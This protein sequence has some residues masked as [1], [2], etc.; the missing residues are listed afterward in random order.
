M[1]AG[2]K[3]MVAAA[4]LT[5][6]A[7]GLGC[8]E[9]RPENAGYNTPLQNKYQPV[10]PEAR[11]PLGKEWMKHPTDEGDTPDRQP[12]NDRSNTEEDQGR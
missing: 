1:K 8:T 6:G 4:V 3:S 5:G 9:Q 11:E 7:L 10:K 12:D 2:L